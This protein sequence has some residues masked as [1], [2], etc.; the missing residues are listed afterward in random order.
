MDNS[1]NKSKIKIKGS[2]LVDFAGSVGKLVWILF[3]WSAFCGLLTYGTYLELVRIN[4]W[5]EI[6]N[7]ISEKSEK[8]L[9]DVKIIE[10]KTDTFYTRDNANKFNTQTDKYVVL[11]DI[12]LNKS[13]KLR[14][15]QL[16]VSDKDFGKTIKINESEEYLIGEDNIKWPIGTFGYDIFMYLGFCLVYLFGIILTGDDRDFDRYMY[17]KYKN[18]DW[19][20]PCNIFDHLLTFPF[21]W[22]LIVVVS[23]SITMIAFWG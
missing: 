22:C 3:L 9:R 18:D 10:I 21:I 2:Y 4:Q 17:N 11:K 5:G 15:E 1:E 13:F 6:K 19:R 23:I 14:P 20:K 7:F 12:K 8:H 16:G